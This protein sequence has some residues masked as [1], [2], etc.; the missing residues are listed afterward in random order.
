MIDWTEDRIAALSD[1][2]VKNLL[3]NAERKSVSD[4]A[5]R[6]QAELDKRN[7]AKPRK[8]GK[9]R[10]G[11]K[12]FEHR[13]SAQLADVGRELAD[14]FDLSEETA[15]VRSEGVKGFRAHKLL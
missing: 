9:G 13:V 14:K 2:E 5:L 3:A 6:C 1:A 11:V 15:K 8:P 7:A 12:E 4:I 10:S